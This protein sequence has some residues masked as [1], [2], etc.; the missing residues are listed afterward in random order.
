MT[1]KGERGT[2]RQVLK[3]PAPDAVTI[4]QLLAG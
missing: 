2:D 3:G 1:D 4:D